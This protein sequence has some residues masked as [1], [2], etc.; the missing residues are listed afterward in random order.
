VAD[1]FGLL[2]LKVLP[3]LLVDVSSPLL[4]L[5]APSSSSDLTEDTVMTRLKLFG[6]CGTLIL[7]H[8]ASKL[9]F[10]SII[11]DE[12]KKLDK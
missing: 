2:F 1:S 6:L 12:A 9:S 8:S 10:L 3:L 5:L 4:V 11:Y 7:I